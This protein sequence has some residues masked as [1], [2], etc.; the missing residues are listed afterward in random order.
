MSAP[1]E[2]VAALPLFPFA[3]P[4][5]LEPAAELARLRAEEPVARVRLAGGEAAWLV[6]RHD[7]ARAVLS[8]HRRFALA[9]PGVGPGADQGPNYS[10]FQD[11]P[12]HTRLRRLVTA[13]FTARRVS[14]LRERTAAIVADH[15]AGMEARDRPVDL[16][17]ALAF[18]FPI[19]V[20]GELLGVPEAEREG[21]R[22][23]SDA[24]MAIHSR[25]APAGSG[26]AGWGSLAQQ[27]SDL[28]ARK[29]REPGD[30]V[31]SALITARDTDRLS[32]PELVSVAVTLIIAGSVAV[33]V[34]TAIGTVLL[35]RHGRL[36][37]LAAD[38]ALAAT[39]VDEVLRFQ[40]ATGDIAR[41]ATEDVELRGVRI[42]AGDKVL[43]S[44]AS[45]NRD[46][47][48]FADPDRFDIARADNAPMALGH[49]IHHCLGAALARMEL[50]V[51]FTAFA[52]RF[53]G[54]RVAAEPGELAWH[55]SE[56]FGDE[57]PETLPVTW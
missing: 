10:L 47:R 45:A 37:R 23:W 5:P 8:D 34:T 46:E 2:S 53:P 50:Q 7:D 39:A 38:P 43:I 20:L 18:P 15:L 57:W 14:G 56:F 30:D 27:V 49:G 13:A 12:G 26:G 42:G 54:L 1:A 11:P 19:A 36:A 44:I 16:M 21:F 17:E 51:V 32:L 35:T 6:T 22:V 52:E 55:R 3:R 40:S 33:S 9:L 41:T 25:G 28:I 48:R 29:R 31:F 4:T 24:L